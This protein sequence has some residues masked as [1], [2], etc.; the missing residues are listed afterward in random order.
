MSTADHSPLT[1]QPATQIAV[2]AVPDRRADLDA[3]QACIAAFLQEAQCE[4]LLV[5]A[6][7]NFSWLTSGA[8]ARGILDPEETPGLY[9]SADQRWA[10]A[11]NV[12][13][14]RLFDEELDG[15]GFQLKEW[16]WHWGREQLLADLCH[17]RTLA[18]DH[19]RDNS[20]N[21]AADLRQLRRLLTP[22]EQ[23]C[24]RAVGSTVS[25]ALE[26]TCRTLPPNLTERE[27]AGQLAHRLFHR[28][29]VPLNISVA[30]DGRS[31]FYRH[32]G[33][34]DSRMEHFVVLAVTARKYGLCVTASR[35]VAFGAPSSIL[36]KEQEAACKIHAT[37]QAS[38]WPDSR[39]REILNLGRRVYLITG[40]EHEW[41]LCPPGHLTGRTPVELALLP[42][43]EELFQ[44]GWAVTWRASIGAA[45]S[46]DTYLV[47]DRGAEMVTSSEAW[48]LKRVRI[49]GADFNCPGFLERPLSE[50]HQEEGVGNRE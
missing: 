43:T 15:L 40:F 24:F 23:A 35:S 31:R 27:V 9:F 34:T 14:Q 10:L 33:F 41:L 16:P 26:A 32:H 17:G 21:V 28:G 45:D 20:K 22:Y 5:L 49:Q 6:P 13:S 37:Y 48:P 3:K 39:P 7:E 8:V 30:G 29:A 2:A 46:C 19:P 47:T 50:D 38:T 44:T 12:D 11:S 36:R 42:S 1:S 18:C 25:H 4:G